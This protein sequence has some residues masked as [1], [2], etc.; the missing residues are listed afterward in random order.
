MYAQIQANKQVQDQGY[1]YGVMGNIFS[2]LEWYA[3]RISGISFSNKD[4]IFNG[5]NNF[6][7]GSQKELEDL[8]NQIIT[9]IEIFKFSYQMY[10]KEYGKYDFPNN[11][12]KEEMINLL[13]KWKS[14][15][16]N[17]KEHRFY[18]VMIKIIN[19]DY[20]ISLMNELQKKVEKEGKDG[21]KID[22]NFIIQGGTKIVNYSQQMGDEIMKEAENNPNYKP[23]MKL[24]QDN[25][26]DPLIKKIEE[27]NKL[28]NQQQSNLEN[29]INKLMYYSELFA[30]DLRI[31]TKR[32]FYKPQNRPF[33][34]FYN[35]VNNDFSNFLTELNEYQKRFNNYYYKN[36]PEEIKQICIYID[37]L[38]NSIQQKKMTIEPQYMNQF[39]QLIQIINQLKDIM[40]QM[41]N[42]NL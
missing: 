21:T 23:E 9:Q 41:I 8:K 11:L 3:Y 18:D 7:C 1:S 17:E 37:N 36:N 25:P 39:E 22:P 10:I 14:I 35:L 15:I 13:I 24:G 31:E 42:N 29:K 19:G 16:P 4:M 12:S 34:E 26:S 27:D 20:N 28:L 32:I 38:S 2:A 30:E 40:S 6:N 33:D 5:Y